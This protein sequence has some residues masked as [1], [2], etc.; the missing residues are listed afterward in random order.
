MKV[1]V[2]GSTGHLG[3][4]IIR[5]LLSRGHSV[6]GLVRGSDQKA[7]AYLPVEI[8]QGDLFDQVAL[9]KLTEDCDALI[10][11]AGIISIAG[12]MN[13]L[14]HQ[15]NVEGT[16]NIM[17]AAKAAGVRRVIHI[18]SVHAYDQYPIEIPLDENRAYASDHAYAYDQSKRDSQKLA[19]SYA[20]STMQVIVVNPTSVIGPYDFKPSKLGRAIMEMYSGKLPFVFHGGFDFCDGRDI[21]NAVVNG[22]QMGTSGEAYLLGGHWKSL[23]E[24]FMLVSSASGKNKKPIVIPAALAIAGLPFIHLQSKISGKEPLYTREAIAAVTEGNHCIMSNKAHRELA[25]TTRPLEETIRDTCEWFLKN[26]YLD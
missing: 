24:L 14:V 13:G 1:A 23:K 25:Y 20:S 9:Q 21:A 22:L 19:L 16:H 4:L 7:L 8:I 17:E 3:N 26:G 2:T 5:E 18:S 15:T 10:H 12:G 11:T 6:K